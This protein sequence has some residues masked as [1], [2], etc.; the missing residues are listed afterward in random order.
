MLFLNQFLNVCD[1]CI[2][3]LHLYRIFVGVIYC[4]DCRDCRD[5]N[6]SLYDINLYL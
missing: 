2:L 4:K 6:L 3:I 1:K 5:L